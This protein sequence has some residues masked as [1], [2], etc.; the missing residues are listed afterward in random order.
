MKLSVSNIGW[1]AEQDEQVYDLL[2]EL[3][4][5]GLEIAP[6]RIF[7]QKPY[8]NPEAVRN[9]ALTLKSRFAL[10]LCSMQSIWYGKSERIAESEDAYQSLMEYTEDAARFAKAAGCRNLVFGC[11][12]NRNL[13]EPAETEMV[14][15][16][17]KDAADAVGKHGVILALEANPIIYNTNF[18]N[19]TRQALDLLQ[20]ID[21]PSLMLNLDFG[22][23]VE[24]GEDLSILKEQI[25]RISH[26]HIS[27][28]FLKPLRPRVEHEWLRNILEENRYDQFISLEMGRP[29]DPEEL[30][31]SIRYVKEVF[32]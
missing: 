26:V 16:F 12:K 11:P 5:Q 17:L 15:R 23:I 31:A 14:E 27:E 28:P 29:G 4:F 24:N 8:E 3:G 2:R 18:V 21:H 25:G 6:T 19:T 7:A 1:A 10:E 30:D 20:K 13:A 32:G 9:F 22:T